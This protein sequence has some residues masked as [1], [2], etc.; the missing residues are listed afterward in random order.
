VDSPNS[1]ADSCAASDSAAT[2][3]ASHSEADAKAYSSAYTGASRR[4]WGLQV[5]AASLQGGGLHMRSARR[6][7]SGRYERHSRLAGTT[8]TWRASVQTGRLGV[9]GVLLR[10]V[11]RL[12]GHESLPR[13]MPD[14]GVPHKRLL[15]RRA[16]TI[17]AAAAETARHVLLGWN[18]AVLSP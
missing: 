7:C 1:A 9:E 2:T 10:N 3:S 8:G 12:L 6:Q 13:P 11:L 18:C 14:A 4:L 17:T 16:Q 15:H 5:R